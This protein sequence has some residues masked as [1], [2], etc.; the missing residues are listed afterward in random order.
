[1]LLITS[2]FPYRGIYMKTEHNKQLKILVRSYIVQIF[3][4]PL[5]LAIIL[6]PRLYPIIDHQNSELKWSTRE[7][8][9]A[10]VIIQITAY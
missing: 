1:M 9:H 4:F 2:C 3:V 6:I 5:T 10:R 7:V 8:K